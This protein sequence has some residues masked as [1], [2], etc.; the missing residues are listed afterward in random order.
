MAETSYSDNY[1]YKVTRPFCYFN[2]RFEVL[3]VLHI[4]ISA[5]WSSILLNKATAF[6]FIMELLHFLFF[7]VSPYRR[8]QLLSPA[9]GL[10]SIGNRL[11]IVTWELIWEWQGNAL[12]FS[13]KVAFWNGLL[14]QLKYVLQT[15]SKGY[16]YFIKFNSKKFLKRKSVF[17]V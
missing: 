2:L 14:D 13:F 1:F 5:V 15:S 12:A 7:P 9:I 4:K 6:N 11:Y 8:G 10:K 16:V 3:T 17:K